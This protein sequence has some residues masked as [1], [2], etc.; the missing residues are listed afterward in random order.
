MVA[1][2]LSSCEIMVGLKSSPCWDHGWIEGVIMRGLSW[3]GLKLSSCEIMV[4]LKSSSCAVE[5][6]APEEDATATRG[7]GIRGE[8]GR[9]GMGP[10]DFPEEEE[11]AEHSHRGAPCQRLELRQDGAGVVRSKGLSAANMRSIE[12]GMSNEAQDVTQKAAYM[13]HEVDLIPGGVAVDDPFILIVVLGHMLL[14][15]AKRAVHDIENRSS[16]N[17]VPRVELPEDTGGWPA[18]TTTTSAAATVVTTAT[19]VTSTAAAAATELDLAGEL[20]RCHHRNEVGHVSAKC[21]TLAA[22]STIWF[23]PVQ[24]AALPTAATAT[25]CATTP[26]TTDFPTLNQQPGILGGLMR[27]GEST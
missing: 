4:G 7:G 24:T 10:S 16:Y 1:L 25:V 13:K 21:P 23:P 27:A 12:P 19:A 20:R 9:E 2:R 6:E 3:F 15:D 8:R 26:T 22:E 11:D 18:T 14:A 17:N 5:V